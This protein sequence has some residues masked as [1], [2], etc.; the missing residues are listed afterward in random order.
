MEIAAWII[1]GVYLVDACVY[2]MHWW[3]LDRRYRPPLLMTIVCATT[4]ALWLPAWSVMEFRRQE[5][6]RPKSL[7]TFRK[8]MA[9][10]GPLKP[11]GPV[12]DDADAIPQEVPGEPPGYVSPEAS[13]PCSADAA[14]GST[15]P[16]S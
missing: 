11:A 15:L 3:T 6:K 14:N 5:A 12:A 10:R 7:E 9:K 8:I 13:K 4:W 1:I 16:A 2:A